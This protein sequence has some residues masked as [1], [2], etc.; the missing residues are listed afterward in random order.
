MA[1]EEHRQHDSL[2][3]REEIREPVHNE[4][5]HQQRMRMTWVYVVMVGVLAILALMLAIAAG[6][7]GHP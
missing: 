5:N 7:L 4:L 3:E 2:D 6:V 1:H